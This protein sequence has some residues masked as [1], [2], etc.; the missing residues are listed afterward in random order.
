M[1]KRFFSL[2][3]ADSSEKDGIVVSYLGYFLKIHRKK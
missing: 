1:E 2:T 3:F